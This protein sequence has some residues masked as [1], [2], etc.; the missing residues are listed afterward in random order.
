L[1]F[2]CS[3]FPFLLFVQCSG[4]H[5]QTVPANFANNLT[6][7]PLKFTTIARIITQKVPRI[8][9]AFLMAAAGVFW[10]N[11]PADGVLCDVF[12][13]L[14]EESYYRLISRDAHEAAQRAY[15]VRG[16]QSDEEFV[17]AFVD[18]N[19]DLFTRLKTTISDIF[20]TAN[21]FVACRNPDFQDNES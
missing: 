21:Q 6:N 16:E 14:K 8:S 4:H 11:L 12:Q 15:G 20:R 13:K 10:E 5:S 3:D 18:A 17:S 1:Q 2:I 9:S 19:P 7:H